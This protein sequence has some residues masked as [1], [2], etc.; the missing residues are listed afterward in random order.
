L[1]APRDYLA[2][3]R[4]KLRALREQGLDPFP[5]RFSCTH[6]CQEI[7]ERFAQLEESG[8]VTL[9]GRLRS[10]RPMGKTAFGHI[11]DATG[12]V[13]IYLRKDVLGE[14]SFALIKQLDL[15]DFLGARGQV[16]R[17]RMGEISVKVTALTVLAKALRPM[18]VVKEKD[19]VLHDAFRDRETRY[20]KRYL[21]L[22]VNP[23]A[24]ALFRTRAATIR[25]LRRFLDERDF[26]EVE[27]P[28]LQRIY[29]GG[30]A[31]PFKTTHRA[32]DMDLYLRIAEELPLK[33]L[34][35][36][37]LDRVYEIGRVF[38]NEGLD[39]QHN[40]EFTL[41]EFYWAYADYHDGMDMVEEMVRAVTQEVAGDLQVAYGE[42]VIDL[43]APFGRRT[44]AELVH[45]RAG[46][47]VLS[48]DR[49]KLRDHCQQLGGEMPA[50]APVGKLI[51]K[52]FDLTVAPELIQPTFVTDH[53]K[54]VSPLAKGHRADPENLVERFEL[55]IAGMEFA[56]AFTELNDPDEQRRRFD[57]QA[58]QREAG[59]EEA[60]P[61]DEG[62]LTALEHGMPP[63]AGVGIGVDRLVMLLTGSLA[64]RDVLLFPHM[65]PLADAESE[66]LAREAEDPRRST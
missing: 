35:V 59:D 18:P 3:R 55:F 16:F 5:H 58:G 45:E 42:A 57:D 27:T 38:R 63:T 15:G 20:R 61:L 28:I 11:E 44:M 39:R 62:F 29:G 13:Q 46:I 4:E 40:P 52:I 50:R 51:E 53:P 65:R 7:H 1:D 37:G 48:S 24:R 36:G 25:A 54:S 2:M 56:N 22:M 33:M 43:A 10:L 17:T 30:A 64:I 26:L 23:D 34:I 47:D 14:A 9:A 49:E 6:R 8:E 32:L 41:L 66:G 31:V 21:D 12:S 60:H 19:G